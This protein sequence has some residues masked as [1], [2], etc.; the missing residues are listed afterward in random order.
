MRLDRRLQ[1]RGRGKSDVPV[2]GDA[3]GG[4]LV[5]KVV[6]SGFV[7]SSDVIPAY[8][9][10]VLSEGDVQALYE[11]KLLR[12]VP[13]IGNHDERNKIEGRELAVELRRTSTGAL[14]VWVEVEM[15]DEQAKGY[16]GWSIGWLEDVYQPGPDDRGP[17]LRF[18]A[19]AAHFS[20]DERDAVVADLRR[21]FRVHGG[22]Y[23][24]LGLG[25]PATVILMM[26]DE[27]IRAM[28]AAVLTG[29]LFEA[30]R[31]LLPNGDR[32]S[33]S[34]F[35]FNVVKNHDG[36]EVRGILETDDPSTLRAAIDSLRDL[37]DAPPG[38]YERKEAGWEPIGHPSTKTSRSKRSAKSRRSSPG[39]KKT[40]QR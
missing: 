14:G 32:T 20:D 17:L 13:L 27:I 9:R 24:Q 18:A 40:R 38:H 36:T 3:G 29:L 34:L 22:R 6:M 23:F 12:E 21:G 35:K 8:G 10:A 19:D 5:A 7:A 2:G 30:L 37:A 28:P 31:R 39:R 16:G 4:R 15:D 33:P 25:P 11:R 26:I 1:V